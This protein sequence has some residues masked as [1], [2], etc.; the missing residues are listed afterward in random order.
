MQ[1]HRVSFTRYPRETLSETI[2]HTGSRRVQACQKRRR[3]PEEECNLASKLLKRQLGPSGSC[4]L[5]RQRGSDARDVFRNVQLQTEFDTLDAMAQQL[6]PQQP[7]V[8]QRRSQVTE[9]IVAA[10]LVIALCH[11]GSC[12]AFSRGEAG[13]VPW[14]D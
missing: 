7:P 6:A 4:A 14:Q 8:Q 9:I 13:E 1:L 2:F 11:S 12:T 3:E 5:R 10:D